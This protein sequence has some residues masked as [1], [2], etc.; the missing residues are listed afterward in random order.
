MK[1]YSARK[2]KDIMNF[3]GKWV[4]LENIPLSELSQSPKEK[5]GVYSLISGY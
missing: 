1:Y 4:D 5:H 3:A 2:S